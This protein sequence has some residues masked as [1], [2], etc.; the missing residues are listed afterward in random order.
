GRS[1]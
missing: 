1:T